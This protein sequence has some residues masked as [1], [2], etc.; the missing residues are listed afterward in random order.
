[1]IN[2]I[3]TTALTSGGKHPAFECMGVTYT[4]D[5]I[6]R[7]VQ[8]FRVMLE[9]ET[10]L[11]RGDRIGIMLPNI[12]QQPIAVY[13]ALL[14]GYVV[15]NFNPLYTEKEIEHQI[16]D[17]G[18]KVMVVLSSFAYKLDDI[19]CPTLSRVIHTQ[20]GDFMG[21]KGWVVNGVIRYV[22]QME[23]PWMTP[24][25]SMA[26]LKY[27]YDL[28][29][30]R[31]E[32]SENNVAM[33]QYTGG[34][35]GVPK[36]VMLTQANL[37]AN[38]EQCH[39]RMIDC[40]A[41]DWMNEVVLPLPLYHVYAMIV[42][43]MVIRN[44][45]K[46]Q[47]IPNPRDIKAFVKI[48]GKIEP[49]TFIGLQTLFKAL[50]SNKKFRSMTFPKMRITLSGGMGL[51]ES[52]ANEWELVTGSMVYEGYGLSEASP[53]VSLDMGPQPNRGYV[54]QPLMNTKA[55]IEDGVLKVTGP[56]VM[57]GYWNNQEETDKVLKNGILDTGDIAELDVRR[58]IKIVD[59]AK[60]MIIVSGFNVYPSEVENVYMTHPDIEECAVVGREIKDTEHAVL[61][62]T[63]S[64][65]I[66]GLK[67]FG[68][69]SL[70]SYKVPSKF[71]RVDELPK[72][73]VGKILKKDI[74]R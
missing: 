62:Y 65:E 69:E 45:G 27:Y 39:D 24:S 60:E 54:G 33:I 32:P 40:P 29:P 70:A 37:G 23:E 2:N 59:R 15:V 36:G 20:V 42:S 22:K 51:S 55:I 63:A 68:K 1:M 14:S 10:T 13:A 3:I 16:N 19:R 43:L 74:P 11:M 58:G 50:T 67:K 31:H 30:L 28:I 6:Y 64:K 46:V 17:S 26:E 7:Y 49:T 73:P 38:I 56:Q 53:V 35:T 18:C 48:L 9:E 57:K 5:E 47:L 44:K 8:A 25:V 34:T 12:V 4:Y 21:M 41:K 52:V 61:Y 66:D 71:V 72:S